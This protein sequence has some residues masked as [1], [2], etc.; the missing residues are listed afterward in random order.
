MTNWMSTWIGR[1]GRTAGRPMARIARLLK[2]RPVL[3]PFG[4]GDDPGERFEQTWRAAWKR[5]VLVL[6]VALGV[7]VVGIQARFVQL[8]VFQHEAYAASARKK[9]ERV[10]HPEA[11]RGDINDRHG[12]M[13]AYSV[14]AHNVF[15]DPTL[16]S[17]PAKTAAALCDALA[18]CTPQERRDLVAKLSSPTEYVRIRGARA[19]TPQ[20]AARVEAADLPGIALETDTLRFYPHK[21]LGA[22]VLGYVGAE[23]RGQ[24]GVE[25]VY[26]DI[27]RGRP[28]LAVAQVNARLQRLE[29]R[30]DRAPVPGATLE[31]TIDLAFQHIVERELER[32]VLENRARGGTAIVMNPAT[33]EVLALAS[34]PTFS[35]NVASR[36]TDDDKRNRAVQEVYEPGSTFKIVTAAAALE[37]G[38]AK[39]S[40]IID[41]SPG[42]ITLGSRRIDDEHRYGALSFEDVIV[43]SSNVGAIRVGLRTGARR[44]SEYV[45]RFGFG[46]PS[47][48]ELPG[49]SRG[50][51]APASLTESG[52][53]SV[54][55]G[56]QISVTPLQMVTAASAVANG[57]LL[58]EPR[59]VRAVTQDGQR[60]VYA[61]KVVRR[62]IAPETAATLTAIMEGV[63]ERGTA[64]LARLDRYQ[65]A[66]KTGT[67]KKVLPGGGYS[68][69]EY[70]A[71]FVGFVPSRRPVFTILVVIDTPRAKGYYGGVVAAPIFKRIAEAGLLHLGVPPTIDP[72]PPVIVASD[73][74]AR[75]AP[76]RRVPA[77]IPAAVP[78]GGSLMPDVRGLNMRTAV[79]ALGDAGLV[80]RVNGS[81]LVVDQQPEAGTPIMPGHLGTIQLARRLPRQPDS[82]EGR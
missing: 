53:A 20:Q 76:A 15:A 33:G 7:W 30:V 5:R 57:G 67:A 63:T 58:M 10:L 2:A 38:I 56:Y 81:G 41:T 60:E 31:L 16:V 9:Q 25:L 8:Q 49:A 61:P 74:D 79:R 13:L 35:P 68:D 77:I 80:V 71:S 11:P 73:R 1:R 4:G 52:L 46:Q 17:D 22:H 65:V 12:R 19:V 3:D 24:A 55:M 54:S 29:T 40:D 82:G 39:P 69:G 44:L 36:A 26:D 70:N 21:E 50:I 78:L 51:W 37:S 6:V 27:V 14:K 47:T 62:A 66:G 32:G 48:K 45:A 59:F 28:G 75:P 64:T 18:D 23:N 42:Y 72:V 43:K 34:Y